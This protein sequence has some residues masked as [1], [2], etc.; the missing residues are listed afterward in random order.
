MPR[1]R[2]FVE[3]ISL[4]AEITSRSFD[5]VAF[6]WAEEVARTVYPAMNRVEHTSSA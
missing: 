3:A 1:V 4:G 5:E 6:G 2:T